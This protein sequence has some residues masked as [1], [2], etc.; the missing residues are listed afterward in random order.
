MLVL[1]SNLY[2]ELEEISVSVSGLSS[3][4]TLHCLLTTT[5]YYLNGKVNNFDLRKLFYSKQDFKNTYYSPVK[6]DHK[7]TYSTELIIEVLY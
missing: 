1:L 5:D 7:W 2:L 4:L 6:I 3:C